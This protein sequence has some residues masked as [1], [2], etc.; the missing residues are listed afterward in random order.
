MIIIRVFPQQTSMTPTDDMAFVGDPPLFRPE[1]DEVHISVCFTWDRQ[2]GERLRQAW[3]SHYGA[4]KL[5]G[6]AISGSR[7]EFVPGR[8]VKN[9]VT[10]TS[11]GCPLRCPWC[12]VPEWEG[13]L[14]LLH[15][16]SG[17]I[18]QDNNLLACPKWHQVEVYKMLR[19]QR[20]AVT[21]AGGLDAR[22]VDD[23][24][25]NELRTIPIKQV[26]FSAD[27]DDGLLPLAVAVKKLPF[28]SRQ[29]LRCYV[30]LGFNGEE[31][32]AGEERLK[33]VWEIGCMPFAQ[34]YQ[35]PDRHIDYAREWK[36]LVRTWS[37]PAAM[38]A[39]MAGS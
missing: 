11:R 3:D 9:G 12:L 18:V 10:F 35:P 31:L 2:E 7:G 21:F 24:L 15:I 17:H 29:Q 19:E 33:T 23:W 1:A 20:R 27:T 36:E 4:V 14:K 30:L 39:K 6:P 25:A 28:L 5:G 8:Y 37:R 13:D 38:K 26:F 16:Q 34:L 32:D 22:L